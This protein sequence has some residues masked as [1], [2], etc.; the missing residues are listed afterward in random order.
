M[1]KQ[2]LVVLIV[3]M[4]FVTS[5]GTQQVVTIVVTATYSPTDSPS[6]T[7]TRT[8]F[9]TYTVRPTRT[10]HPTDTPRPTNTPVPTNTPTVPPEPLVMTGSG[11]SVIDFDW[12]DSGI[13]H[14]INT[15][16]GHFA[17]KS[18]TA[19][20]EYI[21][22]IVNTIGH[23]EGTHL[24]NFQTDETAVRFE[25]TA[26]G[27]WEIQILPITEARIENMPSTITGTGDDVVFIVTSSPDLMIVDAS[28][29]EG[30]FAIWVY[31]IPQRRDLLVNDI[32]PYTGTVIMPPG[33][34]LFTVTAQGP[35]SIEITEK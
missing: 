24:L 5:C 33:S 25:V 27:S 12:K 11:D 15:G 8:P 17:V 22:L 1:K 34:Y 19:S 23:Y 31:Y 29:A 13:V 9:L 7:A 30:H 10:G 3:L 4:L 35:W 18:Y 20:N 21:D 32:A 6:T 16:G 2:I 26:S 28:G 14:I